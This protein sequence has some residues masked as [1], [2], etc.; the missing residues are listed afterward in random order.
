MPRTSGP[1]LA[2]CTATASPWEKRAALRS[3]PRPTCA[4]LRAAPRSLLRA[5]QDLGHHRASPGAH[6]VSYTDLLHSRRPQK[7]L[8]AGWEQLA[9]PSE[10]TPRPPRRPLRLRRA[11]PL[12]GPQRRREAGAR[13]TQLGGSAFLRTAASTA[14]L[15]RCRPDPS[16]WGLSHTWL[17]P[18]R[19]TA[20]PLTAFELLRILVW[21]KEIFLLLKR[22]KANNANPA[23]ACS[24]IRILQGFIQNKGISKS[25]NRVQGDVHTRR[26]LLGKVH[27]DLPSSSCF[28]FARAAVPGA[29]SPANG[30][31]R[32]RQ[33]RVHPGFWLRFI[34]EF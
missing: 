3:Q 17:P 11:A 23:T 21:L 10:R 6:F 33:F 1:A 9:A 28:C 32:Q 20:L 29:A 5:G 27:G 24:P 31:G 2:P 34:L 8:N 13:G 16:N 18:S 19:C 26:A 15:R 7:G 12:L 4:G 22:E 14:R 25:R 30:A